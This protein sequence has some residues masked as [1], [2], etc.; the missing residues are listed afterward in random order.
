MTEQRTDPWVSIGGRSVARRDFLRLL[1]IGSGAALLSA[2]GVKG[3]AK[4]A[5]SG[6]A[7]ATEIQDYWKG[8]KKTGLVNWAQWPLYID[9]NSQNKN[10][11][12]S[13]DAFTKATGIKVNYYEVIQDDPSFLAKILP[14]LQAGQYTGYDV[15]TIT[16]GTSLDRLMQLGYL[17]PLDHSYLQNFAKYVDPKYRKTSYDPGNVYTVPWQSGF[18]GIAYDTTKVPKPITSFFDLW[19]ERLK[20]KVGM[21]ADNEDLPNAVLVA[22]FGDPQKTGP[23]E[24][25]QA[26]AKLK[27]QR[28]KGIVRQYYEQDYIKALSNGDIWA[29]QAWSGDVFQALASGAS[30]LKFVIPK[31][32][33][34]IWTDNLVLLKYAQHPVD[35]LMLMDWYYQPKIAA[36]V[37]EYVNYITPVPAARDVILADAKQAT[38]DDQKSLLDV[39]NSPLVFPTEQDYQKVYNYRTLTEDELTVWNSIFEPIYQG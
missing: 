10:D 16:N 19:D 18:T 38:G 21:F 33:G 39:A 25:R 37:A 4:P 8:K 13:V 36:M 27:E 14:V 5:A 12:P 32:G 11:H 1:G 23:N 20:G 28:D 7:L 17:I 9:V 24:W 22:M 3:A 15:A 2:C 30:N 31:E 26:A 29:S 35:A 34:V 6:S